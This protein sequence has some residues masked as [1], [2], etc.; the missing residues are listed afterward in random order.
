[1]IN[2][3]SSIRRRRHCTG[4]SAGVWLGLLIMRPAPALPAAPQFEQQKLFI[5]GQQGINTYR[6]PSIIS[7]RNGTLLVFCEGR[8]FT[9]ADGS[10]TDLVL[11]RSLPTPATSNQPPAREHAPSRQSQRGSVTW[12]PMQTLLR[13]TSGEAY[14]NPVSIIDRRDGAIFLLVNLYPQPYKDLPAR[15]WLMKS[16]DEGATW[17]SPIDIT[18]G[19]GLRELG[20][21]V[22][23][24]T[25]NGRLVAPTYEG[26]IF[27]DDHG[28][29]WKSGEKIS[30]AYNESQVVQL[31]DGSLMLNVRQGGHR[32]VFLSKDGGATWS[33]PSIDMSLTEPIDYDGCQAGFVRDFRSGTGAKGLLLFS[34]PADRSHRLRMTVRISYDEGKTWPVDRLINKGTGGYSGLTILPDGTIG[35]VYET[36]DPFRNLAFARFNLEW[37]TGQQHQNG[38]R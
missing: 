27:S 20:P 38:T 17:S 3:L 12:Q 22:G 26:V 15:I 36:G 37:L 35:L 6:I 7:T 10:P 19:T 23:I 18:T 25:R 5:G 16:I 30:G 11:K 31:E 34:S 2:L 33:K 24:Q 21:G 9:Y 13:S 4:W 32:A 1:M 29:T 8:R 14:M 28:K